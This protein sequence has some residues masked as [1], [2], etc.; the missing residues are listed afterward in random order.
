MAT[1][2]GVT[3]PTLYSFYGK[4]YDYNDLARLSD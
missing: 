3:T 1:Q 4:Q 2:Q